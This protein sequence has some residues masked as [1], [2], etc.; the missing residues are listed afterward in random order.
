MKEE[1][2]DVQVGNEIYTI[3][4][5]PGLTDKQATAI[6]MQ[7]LAEENK[8]RG[9][10]GL[11]VGAGQVLGG[12][13]AL[14]VAGGV[15]AGSAGALTPAAVAI[16]AGAIGLGG[17][18]GGQLYDLATGRN[19]DQLQNLKNT[20]QDVLGGVASVPAGMGLAAGVGKVAQIA[21]PYVAPVVREGSKRLASALSRG[22]KPT[23][24]Q[25]RT[26]AARQGEQV[27]FEA[28]ERGRVKTGQ[29]VTAQERAAALAR[30]AETE[31]AR[32]AGFEVK[33]AKA[34]AKAADVSTPGIGQVKTLSERGGEARE[35]VVAKRDE[36]YASQTENDKRLR[37]IADQI[38]ADNEAAGRFI[39]DLPSAKSLLDEVTQRTTP[40]PGTSPTATAL[41]TPEEGKILNAVQSA[42][43]DR[44][45]I[46][47][48]AE[49]T[50]AS[51]IDPGSVSKVGGKYVRTFKT[52]FEA[53]DN[54]RRRLGDSFNSPPAGFEGIP[55]HLARD[56]YG[57]VSQVLDDFVGSARADVQANWKAGVESLAPYDETRLGKALSG[58]QGETGIANVPA[59]NVTNRI[60]SGGA[61]TYAQFGELSG[62][63][64]A[65][66]QWLQD[67]IETELTSPTG[68]PLSFEEAARKVGPNSPLG[69]I[70]N[71][72]PEV[73]AAVQQHLMRLSDAER[74]GVQAER[75][76]GF[77]KAR[78]Q[79][80]KTAE[81]Q[82]RAA[83]GEAAKLS[84]EAESAQAEANK[85]SARLIELDRADPKEAV[86][87][88]MTIMR[89]M[90]QSGR[91]D[92]AQYQKALSEIENAAAA[93]ARGEKRKNFITGALKTAGISVVATALGA[94]LLDKD[95][96]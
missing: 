35:A 68:G 26:N 69:D 87:S 41:P 32:A 52:S 3:K 55:T 64:A 65:Q 71:T 83:E 37:P 27:L 20:A 22:A 16:E 56:M 77:A 67:T 39:S 96:K 38:V 89:E 93:I 84:S 9:R 14:P 12:L 30:Q 29:A 57:R 17:A 66:R 1:E 19:R 7:Q 59:A 90:R 49:A 21:A 92:D 95:N 46:I 33:Q 8:H 43:K 79:K 58:T 54:L 76:A 82:S 61:E 80:A 63:P 40:N 24:N 47:S 72:V 44:R 75:F 48:E 11:A 91:I 2:Y 88:A 10:R 6:V 25:V 85:W 50:A 5:Q 13:A 45:V 74:A 78:T 70:I 51:Q 60:K 28:A 73:K 36:I 23:V 42:L 53:L 31:R 94:S 81:T 86:N 34:K 15:T 62:N 4:A 18:T